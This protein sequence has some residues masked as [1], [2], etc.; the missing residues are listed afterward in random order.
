[1]THARR[2]MESVSAYAFAS[3]PLLTD[4][5]VA[6]VEPPVAPENVFSNYTPTLYVPQGSMHA[7]ASDST[8]GKFS[9]IQPFNSGIGSIS[10]TSDVIVKG[11]MITFGSMTSDSLVEI[12]EINGK[13]I[14]RGIPVTITL[15]QGM[16]IIHTESSTLK[17]VIN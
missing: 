14:Y 15:P 2:Y 3:C 11:N 17:V 4:I 8:W 13:V 5:Y 16:Y 10:E 7:Y 9:N 12:V 1:M 6:A